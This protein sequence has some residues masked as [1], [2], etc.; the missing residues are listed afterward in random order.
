MSAVDAT[1]NATAGDRAVAIAL[2]LALLLTGFF[3]AEPE[4][5]PQTAPTVRTAHR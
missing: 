3:G 1:R 4:S 2:F 5:G